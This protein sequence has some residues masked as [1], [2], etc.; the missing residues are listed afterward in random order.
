MKDMLALSSVAVES[1]LHTYDCFTLDTKISS[2]VVSSKGKR[3]GEGTY[4]YGW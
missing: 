4:G 3:G 1:I 2:D